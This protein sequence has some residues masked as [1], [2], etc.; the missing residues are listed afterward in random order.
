MQYFIILTLVLGLI[1]ALA[2]I[3]AQLKEKN[4]S[5]E[6]KAVQH[7][8]HRPVF[9]S[10]S[11][12]AVDEREKMVDYLLKRKHLTLDEMQFIYDFLMD[13]GKEKWRYIK[14][15]EGYY[16][17]SSTGLVESCRY[18]RYLDPTLINGRYQIRV[19]VG[20][21]SKGFS[22]HKVVAQTFIPNPDGAI[23][24]VPKDG[25]Y[26][27]CDV[28]NLMW[29]PQAITTKTATKIEMMEAA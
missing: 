24:V 17:V 21:E 23:S 6:E 18:N 8:I 13:T 3:T 4:S 22:I 27:H 25:D 10:V 19:C 20:R 16:R 28:R 9:S 14:G 7:R 12:N 2:A 26:R 11:S 29:K 1:S 5:K 15:Y